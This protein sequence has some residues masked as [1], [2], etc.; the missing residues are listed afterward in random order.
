MAGEDHSHMAQF[1]VFT[2]AGKEPIQVFEG[3]QMMQ[4]GAFVKIFDK[5]GDQVG[6]AHLDKNQYVRKLQ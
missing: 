4:E 5:N 3:E 1:G 6:A 2:N